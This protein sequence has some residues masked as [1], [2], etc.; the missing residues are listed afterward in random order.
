M[1]LPVYVSLKS[2]ALPQAFGSFDNVTAPHRA[3]MG[4]L[5]LA[6]TFTKIMSFAGVL[7]S[8]V[9]SSAWF[10]LG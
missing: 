5:L 9:V 6:E 8:M 4:Q 2:L 3:E 10:C 7:F 1:I